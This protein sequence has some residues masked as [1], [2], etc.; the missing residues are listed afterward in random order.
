MARLSS[1]AR[2]RGPPFV[3]SRVRPFLRME[4]IRRSRRLGLLCWASEWRDS[5]RCGPG[6]H[7]WEGTEG[8]GRAARSLSLARGR[9]YRVVWPAMNCLRSSALWIREWEGRS[10]RSLDG[11]PAWRS[12]GGG[13]GC[14]ES[15]EAMISLASWLVAR[16]LKLKI[17]AALISGG[18]RRGALTNQGRDRW[19]R[20]NCSQNL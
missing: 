13:T 12:A 18:K 3:A 6:Q 15:G 11:V 1:P 7:L 5:H 8:D 10:P 14:S 2:R 20:T 17:R 4:L 9:C 16:P 19:P